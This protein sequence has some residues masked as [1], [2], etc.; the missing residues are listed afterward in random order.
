MKPSQFDIANQ[1]PCLPWFLSCLLLPILLGGCESLGYYRQAVQ[2]HI[3][4]LRQRQP[5]AKLVDD[6]STPEAL[7]QR[8]CYVLKVREFARKELFLPADR[9]YLSYVNLGRP[10]VAWNVYAAPEFS[11][12]PKTWCFPVAGC[13]AYRAY[14][15]EDA[16][17]GYA[18]KLSEEGY[19][20][21]VGGVTA[22]STLGWFDDPLLNTML[23]F[24]NTR[25][26][27]LI[28]HELA[29]QKLYVPG[30]TSFN[31]SFATAVEQEGVRRWHRISR[32]PQGYE[33]YWTT[34]RRKQ[35]L[36]DLILSYRRHLERLYETDLSENQKRT[37]KDSIFREL[38]RCYGEL[39]KSWDGYSGFDGWFN[40]SLNNA[41]LASIAAYHEFVPAFS[42]MLQEE[43][44][45]LDQFY[46]ECRKLAQMDQI[47]RHEALSKKS[48]AAGPRFPVAPEG[49]ACL[50]TE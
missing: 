38:R 13:V 29:H 3:Q 6:P 9:H 25:L 45:D 1:R 28:F 34:F 32:D 18:R 39:T 36:I 43:N 21:D 40:D 4:I 49:G 12:T 11:L 7:K 24:S 20:T 23:K 44:G 48:G 16:A 5:I 26:A 41:W 46:R 37:K 33:A 15:S 47:A 22:Y 27:A 31:E 35:Q 8:L 30:D 10:Y 14:F 42:R 19:D 17:V 50:P 2:G